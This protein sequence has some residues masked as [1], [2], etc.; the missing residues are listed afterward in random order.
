MHLVN[1]I[2]NILE[3]LMVNW[4]INC[5]SYQTWLDTAWYKKQRLDIRLTTDPSLSSL[6]SE[7]GWRCGDNTL[8]HPCD[9][10]WILDPMP[11]FF[12]LFQAPRQ[13]GPQNWE[14]MNTSP[15]PRSH[16]HIFKCLLLTQHLYYLEPWNRLCFFFSQILGLVFTFIQKP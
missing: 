11:S 16:A 13:L 5:H 1:Q 9:P 6:G 4:V 10:I 2:E 8:F 14:S 3:M 7:H 12:S 15:F